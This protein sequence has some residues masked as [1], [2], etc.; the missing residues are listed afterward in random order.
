MKFRFGQNED[1]SPGH[2]PQLALRDC[3][4]E[5]VGEADVCDFGERRAHCNQV[6]SLQKIFCS[7]RGA[8]VTVKGFNDFLDMKRRKDKGH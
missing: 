7:S 4:K 1:C 8:D 5:A 3:A 6:H 2:M